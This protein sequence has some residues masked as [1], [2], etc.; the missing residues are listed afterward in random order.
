MAIRRHCSVVLLPHIGLS[1]VVVVHLYGFLVDY[2]RHQLYGRV[3]VSLRQ[4]CPA[5]LVLRGVTLC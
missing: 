5:Q 3:V 4:L 2:M 1:S